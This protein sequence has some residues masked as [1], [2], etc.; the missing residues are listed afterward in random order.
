MTETK[1]SLN[2]KIASV[3]EIVDSFHVDPTDSAII[4]YSG[5]EGAKLI[6]RL[7]SDWFFR[8]SIYM[9]VA[10][11]VVGAL[12]LVTLLGIIVHS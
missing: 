7:L 12:F 11:V 10:A 6:D 5:Q 2:D 1:T 4:P 3:Q 8:N 9:A